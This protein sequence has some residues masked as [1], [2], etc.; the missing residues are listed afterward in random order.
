MEE[1][2]GPILG[3]T[4]VLMAVFVP[5]AFLPGLT[6]RMYAQFALVMAATALLSAVN[7]A[8]LKP[9][10][11]A[12]WLRPPKPPAE[13]NL[14]LRGFNRGYAALERGYAGLAAGMVR[15]STV[16]AAL[17]LALAG[18]GVWGVARLPTAFIPI[19][20]Q[21]RLLVGVQLPDGASLERTR[22]ALAEAS[23]IA[24]GVPGVDHVVEIAGVSLLDN[25]ASLPNAGVAYVVL[26]DWG[27]RGRARGQ[28][29]RSLY[30]TL[31]AALDALPEAEAFVIPPPPIQGIG[32]AGGFTMMVELRD[33]SFDF[34]KLEDSAHAVIAAAEAQ[35]AVQ[36]L[37]STFRAGAPQVRLMVD[38]AK[39]ELLGVSVGDAFNALGAFVCS[40]YVNQFNRFGRTFQVYVQAEAD[41]RR[42]P[43]DLLRL[44]VRSQDGQ[45]VPLGAFATVQPET[46]PALITLY[47]L[48][49]AAM[50]LGAPAQGF[51]SGQALRVMEQVA[52]GV[53]PPGLGYDWTAMSYQE[54]QVGAQLYLALGLAIL[55]VYL[56]LA[57]LYESWFAPWPVLLAVPLSLLGPAAALAALGL[58]NNLYT[59]IGLVLLVA[60]SAKNAILIVE[61]ARE[62]RVATGMEL[63]A[64]AVEAARI[65]F[66]PV[67]MTSI[68]LVL[69]VLPLLLATGAGASARASLGLSVVSGM[70]A[71]TCLAVLFVPSLFVVVQGIEERFRARR[72]RRRAQVPAP[73]PEDAGRQQ[74]ALSGGD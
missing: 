30:A 64:A 44:R 52:A 74:P 32:N 54:K 43:E 48:Y 63:R 7:A 34:E 12:L 31:S 25:N 36:R 50:V 15:R 38:R 19:E 41:A 57:A 33:G 61:V 62:R 22:A 35:P 46:G 3:I 10:Q 2:F 56:C 65:R 18:I 14:L 5:A 24:R 40:S 16:M 69:G 49:P 28:D 67:V 8:T 9:T 17:A 68:A 45:M 11:C 4:L 59:Q 1:L 21:G 29:L 23:R 6:G 73:P 27:E 58:A 37:V 53:L 42:Q 66:R 13:R 26:K 70:L 60:L 20:D 51:S 39:A 47:D 72:G 55:L 71:S